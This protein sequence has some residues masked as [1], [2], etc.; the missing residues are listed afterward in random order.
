MSLKEETDA[1]KRIPLFANL[2]PAKL[3]LLALSEKKIL[4]PLEEQVYKDK[5]KLRKT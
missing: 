5:Y 4:L 1:L 3:K 2:D